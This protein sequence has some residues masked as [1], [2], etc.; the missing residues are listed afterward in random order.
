M[1]RRAE[2]QEDG[3]VCVGEPCPFDESSRMRGR[4]ETAIEAVCPIDAPGCRRARGG[5]SLEFAILNLR[6]SVRGR[7]SKESF[8]GSTAMCKR[9]D[10]YTTG[11]GRQR[12]WDIGCVVDVEEAVRYGR[13]SHQVRDDW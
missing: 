11:R 5:C 10:A 7:M 1:R 8:L 9:I 2:F 13:N 12:I 3:T 4:A 6:F